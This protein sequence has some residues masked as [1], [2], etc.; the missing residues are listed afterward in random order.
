MSVT[1]GR[2]S[3]EVARRTRQVAR[4]LLAAGAVGLIAAAVIVVAL[5]PWMRAVPLAVIAVVLALPGVRL[6][7]HRHRL[8]AAFGDPARSAD[9]LRAAVLDL[10]HARRIWAAVRILGQV[11]GMVGPLRPPA[12]AVSGLAL[13]ATAALV[14]VAPIV[15]VASAVAAALA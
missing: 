9:D 6:L 7:R 3:D 5:V 11:D 2:A 10:I 1:A 15:A 14:V 8:L 12:L 4:L 13:V